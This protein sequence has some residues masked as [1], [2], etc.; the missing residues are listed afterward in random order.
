M[1]VLKRRNNELNESISIGAHEMKAPII[2]ILGVVE[3]LLSELEYTGVNLKG[4]D[5][6]KTFIL[7]RGHELP[8]SFQIT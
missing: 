3:V 5:E 2:S 4:S 8:K 7:Q 6:S 1:N